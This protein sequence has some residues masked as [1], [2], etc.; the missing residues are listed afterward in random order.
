MFKVE[1]MRS[2][3]LL[4]LL[5][6][7]SAFKRERARKLDVGKNEALIKNDLEVL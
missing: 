1:A 6:S 2:L 3:R 4:L 5:F 7:G